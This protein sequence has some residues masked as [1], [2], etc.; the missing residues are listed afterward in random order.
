LLEGLRFHAKVAKS[1]ILLQVCPKRTTQLEAASEHHLVCG[2]P[3]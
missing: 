2:P 1:Q 3:A